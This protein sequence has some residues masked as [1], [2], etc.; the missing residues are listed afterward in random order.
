M[1]CCITPERFD[2]TLA[3][4]LSD[5]SPD[6]DTTDA[7]HIAYLLKVRRESTDRTLNSCVN[8][9]NNDPLLGVN[10]VV[11]I[12]HFPFTHWKV[13]IGIPEDHVLAQ[14]NKTYKQIIIATILL[15][16]IAT[17]FGFI[18]LRKV[19]IKPIASINQQLDE[20]LSVSGNKYK[21][22]TCDDKGEIGVL[23]HNLNNR[24]GA[25]EESLEKEA[26]EIQKRMVNEKLLIQQ[27][28]MAAMGE[29]MDAVAHQWK[30]PL[31]ATL[32]VHNQNN[33]ACFVMT[34]KK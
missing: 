26:I 5:S 31:N 3:K 8:F 32:T 33:G 19:F 17:I 4:S 22:L 29:M 12:Y 34:F 24:T 20:N 16:I 15:T 25:L 14:S 9:V 10:S 7:E 1:G 2:G 23:I 30:Q 27:S 13:V 21:V 6:I 28:K 18:L 11:A